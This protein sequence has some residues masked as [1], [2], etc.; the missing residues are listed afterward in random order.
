MHSRMAAVLPLVLAAACG[1]DPK[2]PAATPAAPPAAVEAPPP[3]ALSAEK[4]DDDASTGQIRISDEIQRACGIGAADAYFDFDSAQVA[5]AA[6][7]VLTKL[8]QCFTTGPL[9]GRKMNLAG[10]ADPRG[11]EEYNLV[12]GGRRA[13]NVK[14]FLVSVALPD[15]QAATTSRGEMEA[16]GTDEAGW[17]KDR[18]VDIVLAD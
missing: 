10:H 4:P 1:S 16:T 2:P 11:D 18:R 8:A 7:D 14:K 5:Q 17:A 3:P 6:R 9:K 12:L 15:G 13:D